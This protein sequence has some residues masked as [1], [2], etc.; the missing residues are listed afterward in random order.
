M[1][2]E[3]TLQS[4]L[5]LKLFYSHYHIKFSN[6]KYFNFAFLVSIVV[7]GMW[8]FNRLATKLDKLLLLI[9]VLLQ[10]YYTGK[11]VWFN[12]DQNKLYE[13]YN[14]SIIVDFLSVVVCLKFMYSKYELR[15]RHCNVVV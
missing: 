12:D 2:K 13:A 10:V 15:K 8:L 11:L 7:C 9:I 4:L 3:L 1:H 5:L 14:K 6:Q